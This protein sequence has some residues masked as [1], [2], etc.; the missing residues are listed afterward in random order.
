M[1]ISALHA[2]FSSVTDYIIM[3]AAKQL[4]LIIILRIPIPLDRH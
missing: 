2:P 3:I 1:M 4:Q